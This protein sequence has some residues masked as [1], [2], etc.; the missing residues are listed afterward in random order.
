[1]DE[2]PRS[3]TLSPTGI[4]LEEVKKQKD[5]REVAA[6]VCGILSFV[7]VIGVIVTSYYTTHTLL[8]SPPQNNQVLLIIL[9]SRVV[10]SGTLL[11]FAYFLL[12]MTERLLVPQRLMKDAK[13]AELIK[14]LLGQ[15]NARI[16]PITYYLETISK[17]TPTMLKSVVEVLQA[18][19]D[20]K[21]K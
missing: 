13:D 1:M 5:L 8:I 15:Q 3:D 12:K 14:V 19:K 11:G 4:V 21:S 7:V 17:Y 10:L 9:V 20:Q 6:I 16:K 2:E 18:V